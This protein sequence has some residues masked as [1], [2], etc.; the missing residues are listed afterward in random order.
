MKFMFKNYEKLITKML[1]IISMLVYLLFVIIHNRSGLIPNSP[2]LM[3]AAAFTSPRGEERRKKEKIMSRIASENILSRRVN[4]MEKM[5]K[6][7]CYYFQLNISKACVENGI[8]LNFETSEG[9]GN[10]ICRE[11][12]KEEG[13]EEKG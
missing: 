13:N 4:I 7:K 3:N 5:K 12:I 9:Y 8:H 10:G 1:Y 6:K 11:I 2:V